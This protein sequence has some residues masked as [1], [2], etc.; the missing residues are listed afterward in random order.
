MQTADGSQVCGTVHKLTW[1][2]LFC[3]WCINSNKCVRGNGFLRHLKH[4]DER[5]ARQAGHA[6][7]MNVQ[8]HLPPTGMPHMKN[9]HLVEVNLRLQPVQGMLSHG[10][11][12]ELGLPQ[13]GGK[14]RACA[15]VCVCVSI[16][17]HLSVSTDC[18][19]KHTTVTRQ[20][21]W[22]PQE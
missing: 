5:C 2:H 7:L 22:H 13:L 15:Y 16:G 21:P 10:G 20:L 17:N 9:T 19:S 14:L 8:H 12:E 1:Q 4:L 18:G 6:L 11:H 3:V